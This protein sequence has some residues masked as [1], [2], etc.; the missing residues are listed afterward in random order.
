MVNQI[1][2]DHHKKLHSLIQLTEKFFS[3]L[4]EEHGALIDRLPDRIFECAEKK[5]EFII[6]LNDQF[7]TFLG[8]LGVKEPTRSE[9]DTWKNSFQQIESITQKLPKEQVELTTGFNK[10][11]NLI[12]KCKEQ[13]QVNGIIISTNRRSVERDL[14]LLQNKESKNDIYNTK[15]LKIELCKESKGVKV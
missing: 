7:S 5:K 15:G 11:K 3:F 9:N 14:S 2:P 8:A 6:Q 12:E 10:L 1:T 4:N 13:N